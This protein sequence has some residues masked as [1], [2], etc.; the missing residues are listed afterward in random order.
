MAGNDPDPNKELDRLRQRDEENR[1]FIERLTALHEVRNELARAET[2]DALCRRAIELGL[3]RL[4]FER[5]GLLFLDREHD[6]LRG[7]YGTDPKGAVRDEHSLCIENYSTRPGSFLPK[8]ELNHRSY[9]RLPDVVFRDMGT[10][11]V[12]RGERV[13]APIWEGPV[14]L[15]HLSIDNLRSGRPIPENQCRLLAL[16]ASVLGHLLTRK[17]AESEATRLGQQLTALH[18]V[19][20]T[21]SQ[22]ASVDDLCRDAVE[23]GRQ[24]LGFDR[25]GIWFY[26]RD[27]R[28]LLGSFGT[29]E[30]GKTRDERGEKHPLTDWD[31]PNRHLVAGE[32]FK[33][34]LLRNSDL[35]N[36]QG[37]IVGRGDHVLATLWD[38]SKVI[39]G[40]AADN[41]LSG[42]SI[43]ENHARIVGL[44]ATSLGHLL[45]LKRAE[46]QT[47]AFGRRLTVLHEISNEL[48]KI[49]SFD[50][51]CR[52]AVE[53]GLERLGFDRMSIWFHDPKTNTVNGSFGTDEKGAVR[54]ERHL[55]GM[56]FADS[57]GAEVLRRKVR[58]VARTSAT[59]YGT[60][61]A[62]G[63][64]RGMVTSAALWDGAEII[65]YVSTD[66]EIRRNPITEEQNQLLVLYAAT[67]GH[68]F[69]RK[70]G[71]IEK[72]RLEAQIRH[73][74]KLESLGVLAG[75]IAHDFNNLLMG[76][77]GNAD[78]ALTEL[79]STS[80]AR[81][82]LKAI[83]TAAHRA[84]D[85]SRQMLAYSGKGRFLIEPVDLNEVI[86]EMES[87]LRVSISKTATLRCSL[88]PGLPAIEA[89][90][91]Q[92]RQV[93]MNLITN[94]SEA[95]G[96][97]SGQIS[98]AT[99][100]IECDPDYLKGTYFEQEL[101]QGPY[102]FL[103]VSDTGCGMT[104]EVQER[105]FEP[106]FTTKFMG[107]GLGMS[108][109]LGIV[110]GHRGAVK[111]YSEPGRGTTFKILFPALAAS[112]RAT[113]TSDG[114][115]AEWRGRGIVLLVDDEDVVRTTGRLMLE[116][117]GFQV[118]IARNGREAIDVFSAKA[119]DI[120]CVILDLTMP[121][122]DGIETF[123]ELRRIHSGARVIIT[124][125]YTEQEVVTRFSG[126]GIAGFIQK[127]YTLATLARGLKEALAR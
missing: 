75:G 120:G 14:P 9:F 46:E 66:N 56:R 44:Y 109:V 4:G 34:Q 108:A 103:E 79:P 37:Q 58:Y 60:D 67:L 6:C 116:K 24:R 17:K 54:D 30:Q 88:A 110:R 10:S 106:F 38:G 119:A 64:G 62:I 51:L 12:G 63:I 22:S 20:N 61:S 11:V 43:G 57:A 16:Y 8:A 87:L 71:E 102:V 117:L 55:K 107:R 35:R 91:T 83:E 41:L 81:A 21:L 73:T 74:Q 25:M 5:I 104:R 112:L 125:G 93:V 105:I 101:P 99:G 13:M 98:V 121:N 126:K 113:G 92:M 84:A 118:L 53:L 115:P 26:D 68:L 48:L 80:P 15:G 2:T 19:A 124:S 32:E 1:I 39:G 28:L 18:E 111:I 114:S 122:M 90:A 52:R 97:N 29:D 89:D 127:P 94:A 45:R 95:I 23:L 76:I 36:A 65:G 40:L 33:Y 96:E 72:Q 86:R 49:D 77:L 59:H 31:N 42:K 82:Y 123:Q 27:E 78:L 85:L 50:D 3:E 47:A 100:V 70:R 69:T 7:S